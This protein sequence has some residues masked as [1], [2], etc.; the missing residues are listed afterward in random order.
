M[1]LILE[2]LCEVDLELFGLPDEL[3]ADL[4]VDEF[5]GA[6][7]PSDFVEDADFCGEDVDGHWFS[8]L[9]RIL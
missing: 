9:K 3:F 1:A 7:N 2:I 5:E 4:L 8:N 6:L